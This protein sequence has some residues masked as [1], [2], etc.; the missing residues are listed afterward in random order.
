YFEIGDVEHDLGK[1]HGLMVIEPLLFV[2]DLT[3]D[4]RIVRFVRRFYEDFSN[5]KVTPWGYDAQLH[6]LLDM[7]QPFI[8]HG[9]HTVEHL[10]I[11]LLL[12]YYTG[13]EIYKQAY[14]NAYRK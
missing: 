1:S 10:R 14:E 12:Y 13:E 3:G 2:Y 6:R 5:S 11:P 7:D 4:E 9:A 8:G